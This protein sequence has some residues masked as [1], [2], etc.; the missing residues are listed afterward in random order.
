M[1]RQR[2]RRRLVVC[3]AV[4]LMVQVME[5]DHRGVAALEQL[6]I[7]LG[8]DRPLL[9]GCDLSRERVHRVAPSPEARLVRTQPL[10]Q[11]GQGALEGVAVQID[12]A[13]D[14][15]AVDPLGVSRRRARRDRGDVARR[16]DLDQDM[17]RPALA[18]AAPCRRDRFASALPVQGPAAW[19][20]TRPP[21]TGPGR[22]RAM[23]RAVTT[24]TGRDP[25]H[26]RTAVAPSR[27]NPR[28]RLELPRDHCPAARRHRGQ[29]QAR[30]VPAYRLLQGAWC[31]R[32][33]AGPG[34]RCACARGDRGK[35]RQSCD[36]HGLGGA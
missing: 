22:R 1:D 23:T 6:D 10:G 4:G 24:D 34:A 35:R 15:D 18:A 3:P 36:R 7:Q 21:S 28:P 12:H 26:R 32:R 33:D 25:S 19:A 2:H 11:P 31:P 14:D 17:V 5:L 30:A 16:L 8:R 27:A 9:V 13:G 29:P 20:E